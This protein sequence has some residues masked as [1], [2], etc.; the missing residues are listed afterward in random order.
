MTI[1]IANIN[2]YYFILLYGFIKI[3]FL[4]IFP[5]LNT[6]SKRTLQIAGIRRLLE[7]IL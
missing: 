3:E 4:Y 1:L 5:L 6:I 2:E 7:T